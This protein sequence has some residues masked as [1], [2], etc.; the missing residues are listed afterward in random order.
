MVIR[1]NSVS[2]PRTKGMSQVEQLEGPRLQESHGNSH[3]LGGE[4]ESSV[5][6]PWSDK[7]DLP[8]R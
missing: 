8:S 7:H 1:E 4:T 3:F 2:L 5:T 6:Y